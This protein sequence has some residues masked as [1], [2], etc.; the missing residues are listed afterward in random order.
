MAQIAKQTLDKIC[1]F[2][3]NC[4]LFHGNR[5]LSSADLQSALNVTIDVDKTKQVMAL[6]VKRVFDK[7]ELAKLSAVKGAM[8]RACSSIGAPFLGGFAIPDHKAQDLAKELNVLVTKGLSLKAD[9]MSRY[10]LILDKF[11]KQNPRWEAIIRGNAFDIAYVDD[12]IQFDWDGVRISAGDEGGLMAK[13]L[14]SKVGGLLGN[15][16]N[17]IAK[18]SSKLLDESLKNRD[19]VTRKAFRPLLAMADK[20]DGFNFVDPRVGALASMIRHV[21]SVMPP[22]GRIEGADLRNLYGL[23]S[24]LSSP[25]QALVIGTKVTE[26]DVSMVYDEAFGQPYKAVAPKALPVPVTAQPII[27]VPGLF[28]ASQGAQ[29]PR[30]PAFQPVAYTPPPAAN[31][32]NF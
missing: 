3:L 18:A 23:T 22:E 20:L 1:L 24:M 12:Q 4:R 6:G 26:S 5:K 30:G 15:L 10:P 29:Q 8:Q 7:A 31:F 19:G 14:E 21:L 27:K 2:T 9:L 13:G 11:A 25:D 28:D 32:F 16:L 17:D